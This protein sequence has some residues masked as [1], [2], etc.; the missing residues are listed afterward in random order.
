VGSDQEV[1]Q[2]CT[3]EKLIRRIGELSPSAQSFDLWVP[4][5]LTFGGEAIDGRTAF[6]IVLRRVQH[7]SEDFVPVGFMGLP[8]GRLHRFE[9]WQDD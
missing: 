6:E 5:Y 3:V 1:P 7:V 8:G 4:E 2:P 9:R